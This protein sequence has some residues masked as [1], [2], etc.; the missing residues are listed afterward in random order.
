MTGPTGPAGGTSNTLTIVEVPISSAADHVLTG[1]E[2]A[3]DV[4]IF[5]DSGGGPGGP[6]NVI[7]P[8]I[9]GKRYY[10][11]N[12][13]TATMRF[14]KPGGGGLATLDPE[15][16]KVAIHVG[17]ATADDYILWPIPP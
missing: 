10:L 8:D 16:R 3:A 6:F 12:E 15:D 1:S 4:L 5:F 2:A 7:A 11:D 14:I 17:P 13:T 9:A